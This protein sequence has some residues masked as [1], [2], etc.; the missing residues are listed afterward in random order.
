MLDRVLD[1]RLDEKRRQANRER[2]RRGVDLHLE[3]R[4][5]ARLLEGQ[6]ALDVLELLGERDELAGTGERPAAVVRKGEDQLAGPVRVGADEAGDRVQAV[7]EE[8]RLDLG[9]QGLQL[10]GCGGA[11]GDGELGEL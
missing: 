1:E 7:E 2:L 11:R 9:L 8:M 3:L 5:K 4:A 6:V 10:R